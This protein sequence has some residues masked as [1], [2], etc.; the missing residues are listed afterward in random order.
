METITEIAPI[1]DAGS[2]VRARVRGCG[3]VMAL[4]EFE[5]GDRCVHFEID[6]FLDVTDPRFESLA[7]RGVRTTV[8]GHRGQV[9][10]T[11]KLRGQYSQGLALPL[12]SFPEIGEA[13]AGE[14]VTAVLGV[15][16]WDPP[17]PGARSRTV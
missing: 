7:P 1:P 12:S 8:D 9:L 15:A 2:I 11:A 3:V 5:A 13:A 10:K 4:G 16:T 17:V 14:D 6:S